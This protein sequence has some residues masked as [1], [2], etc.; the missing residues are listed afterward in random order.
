VETGTFREL[1]KREKYIGT[2]LESNLKSL[3]V[4]TNHY[5]KQA[6]PDPGTKIRLGFTQIVTVFAVEVAVMVGC[7]CRLFEDAFILSYGFG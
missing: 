3:I 6:V 2:V 1:R 4:Q 7:L 5:T